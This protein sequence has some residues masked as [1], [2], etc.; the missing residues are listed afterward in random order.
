MSC[1]P[2]PYPGTTDETTPSRWRQIPVRTLRSDRQQFVTA[3]V[4]L[5]MI[6]VD[7]IFSR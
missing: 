6:F 1:R 7:N 2:R 4:L 3:M 5:D